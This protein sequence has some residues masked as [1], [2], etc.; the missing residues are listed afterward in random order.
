LGAVLNGP[1]IKSSRDNPPLKTLLGDILLWSLFCLPG[2]ALVGVLVGGFYT[3]LTSELQGGAWAA[4]AG[5]VLLGGVIGAILGVVAGLAVG[6]LAAATAALIGKVR[7][8]LERRLLVEVIDSARGL[9]Y[10]GGVVLSLP[11]L[12]VGVIVGIIV[13]LR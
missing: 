3:I 9:L 1:R 2:G 4:I 8:K 11:G 10:E 7:G 13:A 5:R 6:Q 12:C